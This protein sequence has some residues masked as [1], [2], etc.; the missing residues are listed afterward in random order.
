[1]NYEDLELFP[2]P[3]KVIMKDTQGETRAP[4][5][6][7]KAYNDKEY[8]LFIREWVVSLKDRYQVRGLVD[9]EIKEGM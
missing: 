3:E 5:E 2:N 1:M 7:I 6:R 8:E 4:Y 9:L